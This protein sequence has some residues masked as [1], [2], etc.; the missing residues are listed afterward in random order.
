MAHG[1][2][3]A[4]STGP[5]PQI[6]GPRLEKTHRGRPD[7]CRQC[8]RGRPHIPHRRQIRLQTNVPGI[9][10]H[11]FASLRACRALARPRVRQARLYR[12]RVMVAHQTWRKLADT[13]GASHRRT[14]FSNAAA[15]RLIIQRT[16]AAR[17]TPPRPRTWQ[18]VETDSVRLS[19]PRE[20]GTGALLRHPA[21]ASRSRS[22]A[23]LR[24]P[25]KSQSA[26]R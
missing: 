21:C 16:I 8:P 3:R 10:A 7:R 22:E 9:N 19:P 4:G 11:H 14:A 2:G 26:A 1:G 24:V 18:P 6:R 17:S 12:R 25:A 23:S 13:S 20:Q 5:F 15:L